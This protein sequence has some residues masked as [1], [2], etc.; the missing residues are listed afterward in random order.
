MKYEH[1]FAPFIPVYSHLYF[2]KQKLVP[3]VQHYVEGVSY[4]NNWAN[5]QCDMNNLFIVFFSFCAAWSLH[6]NSCFAPGLHVIQ[7]A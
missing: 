6:D 5:G 2:L 7:W 1:V 3:D 4:M